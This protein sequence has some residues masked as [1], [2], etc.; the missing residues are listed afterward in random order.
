MNPDKPLEEFPLSEPWP[1]RR[2]RDLRRK[3]NAALMSFSP[4]AIDCLRKSFS[5]NAETGVLTRLDGRRPGPVKATMHRGYQLV[6]FKDVLLRL[7]RLVWA[8]HYNETPPA[9]LD[10]INRDRTDNRIAN[11]RPAS[12]SENRRNSS[13]PRTNKT[14]FRG[15]WW[16]AKRSKWVAHLNVKGQQTSQ[17]GRF[18]TAEEAARAWD[19]AAIKHYGHFAVTNF[20][21]G[22]LPESNFAK[23]A[24][25]PFD[26]PWDV[27]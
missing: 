21:L 12:A 5:Y 13:L 14:G 10:H 3:A 6:H 16:D 20:S 17:V 25:E 1:Q 2:A 9:I 4:D 24:P 7:H 23:A 11:L 26:L 15:I 18:V 19:A 27:T 22:L 8:L